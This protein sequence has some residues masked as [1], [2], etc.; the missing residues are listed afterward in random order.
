MSSGAFSESEI[1]AV[2]KT[3]YKRR[4]IRHFHRDPI[5]DETLKRIIDAA[6]HAPS[7]GF[8]QPW[9]FIVIRQ[10]TT[11]SRLK[12]AVEKER[13]ALEIHY[14]GERKNL[15]T[16]LKVEGIEEAPVILCVT[17]D[18]WRGGDHV[19]GRNS[20]PETDIYSVSCAIQN[21]WLAAR[22]EGLGV[23]WVTFYKKNDIRNILNIPP[24]IDPV[25]LLCIGYTSHFSDQPL[26][27]KA[28][29]EKRK[30]LQELVFDEAWGETTILDFSEA[31]S[32]KG[33]NHHEG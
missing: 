16:R 23:G 15:Y 25:G 24:H 14:E 33:E 12:A 8:M 31:K 19:L 9:N 2:Y 6:H 4:D 26:L 7:V 10:G 5:S 17:C 32:E 13:K 29:W 11:K 21:L 1:K 18:P 28:G 22:A 27:E 3:I 20:I 30:Q